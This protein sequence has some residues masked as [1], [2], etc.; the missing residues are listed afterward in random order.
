MIELL[1]T[2]FMQRALAAGCLVG[3]LASYFGVFVVQRRLSFLGAGLGHA[4]FGGV[5]LGLLLRTEPL[6]IAVPFTIVVALGIDYIRSRTELAGDTAIG[7][8]FAVAVA[9]GVIFLSLREE[10]SADAFAYLFGSILAVTSADLWV[11]AGVTALAIALFP[12]WNRWAY[13]TFDPELARAD[14]IKLQR[15]DVI[16]SV[17]LAV[18]VVVAVKV[19]GILLVA[20]FLVIPAAAARLVSTT[21]FRMTV[22]S[23]V[24]GMATAV[25]GLFCSYWLDVPSGATIILVQAVLFGGA[26]AISRRF[27][28]QA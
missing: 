9:L 10:Y 28:L 4:A 6:W 26:A 1:Q 24:A 17:L 16:L 21:F 8:V 27:D 22:V 18:T 19:V 23:V 2:P 15:D 11:T 13:A 25:I 7:V 20:A 12:L 14:G 3:F 5:A